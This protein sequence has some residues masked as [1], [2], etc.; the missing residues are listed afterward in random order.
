MGRGR[1]SWAVEELALAS[2]LIGTVL[3]PAVF[4]SQ[5]LDSSGRIYVTCL[6]KYSQKEGGKHKAAY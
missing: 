2:V 4:R 5:F 1:A 3:G 6:L